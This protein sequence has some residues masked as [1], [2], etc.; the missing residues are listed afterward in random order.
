MKP[1]C[2][3]YVI[4]GKW[5]IVEMAGWL[6]ESLN[7]VR[8]DMVKPWQYHC[9]EGRPGEFHGE[10]A[11]LL[12]SL[13][14]PTWVQLAAEEVCAK[15]DYVHHK[16]IGPTT[17]MSFILTEY[18]KSLGQAALSTATSLSTVWLIR[19]FADTHGF[20]AQSKQEHVDALFAYILH[21]VTRMRD[22]ARPL[23][24]YTANLVRCDKNEHL[25]GWAVLELVAEGLPADSGMR[26]LIIMEPQPWSP[27]IDSYRFRGDH[28]CADLHSERAPSAYEVSGVD[29]SGAV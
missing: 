3:N 22:R 6:H 4:R 19:Q 14:D 29:L 8:H 11:L 26:N 2:L 25:S 17:A 12:E 27:A 16:G 18:G 23:V 15:S 28:S 24:Q 9:L 20:T 1:I 7:R 10:A 13:I 5:V 21:P